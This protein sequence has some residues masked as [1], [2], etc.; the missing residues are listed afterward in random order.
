MTQESAVQ[1][2]SSLLDRGSDVAGP[3]ALYT[4]HSLFIERPLYYQLLV[5]VLI[6][7]FFLFLELFSSFCYSVRCFY[8]WTFLHQKLFSRVTGVGW[9]VNVLVS[10][11]SIWRKIEMWVDTG[12][13]R[14]GSLSTMTAGTTKCLLSAAVPSWHCV[15]H[16]LNSLHLHLLS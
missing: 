1:T 5:H 10:M 3:P 13:E 8:K 11:L 16:F 12:L 15:F 7:H 4:F 2:W 14:V 9:Y 6:C